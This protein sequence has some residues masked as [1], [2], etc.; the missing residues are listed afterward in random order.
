MPYTIIL[1]VILSIVSKSYQV[2]KKH[3]KPVLGAMVVV[4]LYFY[5]SHLR[6]DLSEMTSKY[7]ESEAQ[8]TAYVKKQSEIKSSLESKLAALVK[9][10]SEKSKEL[11][12]EITIR[13]ET[14]ARITDSNSSLVSRLQQQSEANTLYYKSVPNIDTSLLSKY[15]STS[16][17]LVECSGR[18]A[19]LAE[20]SDQLSIALHGVGAYID[21]YNKRII[22]F[23]KNKELE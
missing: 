16:K 3:W 5:I 17:S 11:S 15:E 10:S 22:E 9:T 18:V 8:H 21:D 7:E 20:E 2:L 1:D 19:K 4:V 6:E 23:N 14:I 12:R 13:N